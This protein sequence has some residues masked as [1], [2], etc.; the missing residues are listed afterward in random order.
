MQRLSIVLGLVLVGC[1][2][3]SSGDDRPAPQPFADA[4][5]C[6]ATSAQQPIEGETHVPDC[7]MVSYVSNPPSSGNHYPDL[8]A[9]HPYS[10]PVPRGFWV[11]DLEH[12]GIVVTYQCGDGC[13]ALAARI[14]A[15]V[16]T[17]PPD[18]SCGDAR[19]V[20]VTPDPLLD[21]PVAASAWG[22]TLRATCFDEAEFTRFYSEHVGMAPEDVCGGG[23]EP[24]A[25]P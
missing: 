22:W 16:D 3:S 12:G 9:Y 6:G 5:P 1:G 20:T 8:A 18:P 17:L 14:A 10:T 15:W 2:H 7:S 13:D 21:V 25:C 24:P 19:R 23:V 4:G 11:H